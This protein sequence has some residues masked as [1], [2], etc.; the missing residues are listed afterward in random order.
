L[1]NDTHEASLN[2]NAGFSL[3]TSKLALYA[4]LPEKRKKEWR[5]ECLEAAQM[6]GP[7]YTEGSVMA[8]SNLDLV[9]KYS[10]E[11]DDEEANESV[12]DNPLLK[13]IFPERVD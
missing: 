10:K 1:N 8:R 4:D 9:D 12:L 13:M 3:M 7:H 11:D 5:N 2:I 6:S